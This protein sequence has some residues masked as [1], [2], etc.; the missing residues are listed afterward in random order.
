M[1]IVSIGEAL[2]LDANG[3]E[4]MPSDFEYTLAFGDLTPADGG[5]G[6]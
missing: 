6:R 2:F 3:E 5:G 1:A 4:E